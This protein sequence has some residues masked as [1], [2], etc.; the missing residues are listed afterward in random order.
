M[1]TYFL[2]VSLILIFSFQVFAEIKDPA[3]KACEDK[4]LKVCTFDLKDVRLLNGPFKHAQNLSGK[5]LMNYEPDRLLANFRMRAGLERKAEPYGGWESQGLM[6]HSLGHYLSALTLMYASTGE[7]KYKD[8]ADY[9]VNELEEIQKA[10]GDGYIMCVPRGKELFKEVSEGNITTQRFSLNGCWAPLYTLHKEMS[11]LRDAYRICSNKKALDVEAKAADW[12]NTIIGDLNDAQMQKVMFCEHGGIAE[13]L[14]DLAADTGNKKYMQMA[15][16]FHHKEMMDPMIEQRDILSGYHANTQI[17]KFIAMARIYELTGDEKYKTG[18][19]FAWDR[20]AH[21]HSYVT[22]GHGLDEYFGDP[23]KLNNRLG[24]NTSETCNVYNMLKLS[25]HLFC[26]EPRASVAD[27]YER[28]LYNHILSS[29]HPGDGRVIYNLTLEMG[30]FKHYQDPGWFT[31]C[32]GTGMENH[33]KY[34]E[35]IYYHNDKE[36]YVNLFIASEL[37]WKEKGLKITQNTKFPDEDSTKLTLN[38]ENP[39]ELTV[40]IRYPHWA[41][42]GLE[43]K[44]NGKEEQVTSKPSSYVKL[45][46]TWKDGDVIDV[47]IPMSLRLE[48]MP[49]NPKRVAIMYGPLVLAGE[50]GPESDPKAGELMYVPVLLTGNKP[51][52]EWVKPVEDK[53]NTF[54]L[55]N[56]GKPR[57]VELYPFHNMHE[58]RYTI[59]W[60]IFTDEEWAE[61]QKEYERIQQ[62]KLELQA[63]TVDFVQ[64]GE[65]QPE[66][67]HNLQYENSNGGRRGEGPASRRAFNGGWF[68]YDLKVIDEP[69]ILRVTYLPAGRRE[70]EFD[71]L[72]D[73]KKFKTQA[74]QRSERGQR[75]PIVVD[76]ELP[77]GIIKG[78]EKIT[79]KF[80]AQDEDNRT[81]SVAGV[82]IM[83]K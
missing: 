81:G 40:Y 12:L 62:E 67:N 78:K 56:V 74:L 44:V 60:D 2:L 54:K 41:K 47:S 13:S 21:H 31:C 19:E 48:S 34:G 3:M 35:C 61:K 22:G 39:V 72:I 65:Q 80:A 43:I 24:T 58:K 33:S 6:G 73:G 55:D 82:R 1:R 37:N 64:P 63:R 76:Y 51:V 20:V 46:R 83:K 71:I 26:F 23:D 4:A 9:I 10:N 52:E 75:E 15:Y 8:R 77:E 68:S 70:V 28:G 16:K 79:V 66:I 36:L 53:P 69:L 27:F 45:S 38:C 50:L 30:G 14:A 17:P 42:K 18:A 32:I 11:G 49:D 7:E 25:S 59:Y 57:D 29:Q 5:S